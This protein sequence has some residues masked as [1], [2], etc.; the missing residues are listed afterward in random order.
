MSDAVVLSR[1]SMTARRSL[2]LVVTL[3]A[4]AAL[5]GSCAGSGFE[6]AASA[7]SQAYFRVPSDWHQ[8]GTQAMLRAQGL[9]SP[10]AASAIKWMVGYDSAPQPS[11]DHILSPL[12]SY[13]IVFA[14]QRDLTPAERDVTSLAG[15]RD[16]LFNLDQGIQNKTVTI[17]SQNDDLSYGKGFFGNRYLF[18]I[19]LQQGN[20]SRAVRVEQTAIVDTGLHHLYWQD[21]A[22]TAD[23]FVAN[24]HLMD[25]I[26]TSW[27]LKQR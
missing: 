21:V 7:D 15:I 18:D 26:V 3:G 22:C 20:R 12:T 1:G 25:Q 6:F 8:Y 17:I 19:V 4:T 14:F 10:G 2:L 11:I 5:L 13:P 23:C 9:R 16:L 27:T 24:Q